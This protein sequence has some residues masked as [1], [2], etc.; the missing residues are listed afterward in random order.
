MSEALIECIHQN[1]WY[2]FGQ[3]APYDFYKTISL[4]WP[5]GDSFNSCFDKYNYCAD[6]HQIYPKPCIKNHLKNKWSSIELFHLVD[7]DLFRFSF[8]EIWLHLIISIL[9]F[10]LFMYLLYIVELFH[11]KLEKLSNSYI[12]VKIIPYNFIMYAIETILVLIIIPNYIQILIYFPNI[13]MVLNLIIIF[14]TVGCFISPV[15]FVLETLYVWLIGFICAI[16]FWKL[17]ELI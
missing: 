12:L 6:V 15:I 11:K 14:V 4:S 8:Y 9:M 2:E 5:Y 16:P 13:F 10:S 17:I 7:A 3:A 1:L